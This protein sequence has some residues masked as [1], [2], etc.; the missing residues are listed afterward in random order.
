MLGTPEVAALPAAYTGKDTQDEKVAR[1]H[2]AFCCVRGS[3]GTYAWTFFL[4]PQPW[5]FPRHLD[6]F[7]QRP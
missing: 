5:G 4:I 2:A 6:W 1:S 7:L 3:G